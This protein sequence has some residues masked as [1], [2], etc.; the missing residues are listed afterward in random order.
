MEDNVTQSIDLGDGRVV[1][2]DTEGDVYRSE[3]LVFLNSDGSRRW[4]AELPKNS[5]PDRFVGIVLDGE[6][7]RASTWSCFT[8]WLDPLTGK[9]LRAVFAK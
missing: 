9:T 2:F 6:H 3:N 5:G 7:I 1:M 8:L 4:K